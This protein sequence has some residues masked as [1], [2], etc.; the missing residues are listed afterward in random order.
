[1]STKKAKSENKG[2]KLFT[3][4]IPIGEQLSRAVSLRHFAKANGN[5]VDVERLTKLIDRLDKE[6]FDG[7]GTN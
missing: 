6:R 2:E 1:M 4:K 7:V 3:R 5:T